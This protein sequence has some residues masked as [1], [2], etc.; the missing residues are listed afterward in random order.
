MTEP[1]PEYVWAFP[2]EKPARGRVWLIVG[3][4]VLAV[5]IAATVFW[6]FIRP[7]LGAV[8]TPAPTVSASASPSP[9]STP[10]ATPTPTPTPSPSSVPSAEPTASAPP[11]PPAPDISAFRQNVTPVLSDA[12][13]G[14]QIAGESDPQE[15]AQNVGFLQEDAGRLSDF[16][17][18]SSIS[19]QWGTRLDDYTRSLQSLRTA[20]ERGGSADSELS[21]A[22]RALTALKGVV[23]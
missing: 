22:S 18:P 19:A 16:V 17:A 12:Q 7:S 10:S 13:R 4:V 15:A 6:L 21:A 3:L 5:A 1:Q 2:E 11:P 8:Q 20:Y 9:A 14:L 23:D